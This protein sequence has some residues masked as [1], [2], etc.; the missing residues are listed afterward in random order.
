M[1]LTDKYLD[2]AYHILWT[3]SVEAETKIYMLHLNSNYVSSHK[4]TNLES[5]YTSSY[6]MLI[7]VTCTLPF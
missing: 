6:F 2:A 3:V 1:T 5:L 4:H 7:L